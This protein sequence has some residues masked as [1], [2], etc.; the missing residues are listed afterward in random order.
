MP[1]ELPLSDELVREFVIAGHGDFPRLKAMLAEHP[2]LLNAAYAWSET[3][4]ETALQG[5]AQLGLAPI[6]EFLLARGAPLELCTAAFLG[7]SADV[8]RFLDEDP[9]AIRAVGAHGIPL[10]PHAVWSGSLELVQRLVQRGALEGS[11]MALENA[12]SSRQPEMVRWLVENTHPDLGW[13]N[14]LG[15][16]A[17]EQAQNLKDG[18][19]IEIL[20]A[21][22]KT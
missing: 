14:Y 21:A 12:I 6:A 17:L 18:P 1:T 2:T 15:K 3:D 8:E 16:T 22:Q 7:R 20:S 19:M 5:A 11:S 9:A 4:H 10:L 13:K